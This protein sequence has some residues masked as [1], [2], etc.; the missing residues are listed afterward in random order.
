MFEMPVLPI[1]TLTKGGFEK[2]GE[3]EHDKIEHILLFIVV[4]QVKQIE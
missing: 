1:D 2:I 3:H 4:I